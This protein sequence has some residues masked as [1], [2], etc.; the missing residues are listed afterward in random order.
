MILN[1]IPLLDAVD[2]MNRVIESET[3]KIECN[4][5]KES[6]QKGAGISE[7]A[8]SGNFFPRCS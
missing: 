2:T 6:I 4:K 5:I 8:A 3:L 1:G 7:A